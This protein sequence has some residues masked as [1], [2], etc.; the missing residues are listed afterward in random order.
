MFV[1]SLLDAS[2]AVYDKRKV[3]VGRNPETEWIGA[4]NGLHAEGW[5]HTLRIHYF[6]FL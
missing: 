2:G 3:F 5:A 1:T 6:R 4:E